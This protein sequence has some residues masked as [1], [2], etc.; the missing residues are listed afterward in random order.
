MIFPYPHTAALAQIPVPYPYKDEIL[1]IY[2]LRLRDVLDMDMWLKSR[3]VLEYHHQIELLPP[4]EREEFVAGMSDII[5]DINGSSGR[6]YRF[7]WENESA[8]LHLSVLLTRGMVP[9]EHLRELLF[10]NGFSEEAVDTIT[11]M[12]RAVWRDL[13]PIP[14]LNIVE[15]K[16]RYEATKEESEARIYHM[17]AEKYHWT[18]EQILDLTDYQAFWFGYMFPEERE[19]YE[20]MDAMIHQSRVSMEANNAEMPPAP[21]PGVIHF[22]SPEEYEAWKAR[23]SSQ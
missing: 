2:P 5:S 23:Q 3:V 1:N 15:K 19:H 10:P 13:P 18:Y 9:E 8:L 6:G 11:E 21:K 20:D 12:K 14:K 4:S 22:N 16:P 7:L 17:L